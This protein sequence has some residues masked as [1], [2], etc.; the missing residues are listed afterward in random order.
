MIRYVSI[1]IAAIGAL[2]L[3]AKLIQQAFSVY[4]FGRDEAVAILVLAAVVHI[5]GSR[6]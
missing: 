6:R 1:P 2:M 3:V 5:I 4:P